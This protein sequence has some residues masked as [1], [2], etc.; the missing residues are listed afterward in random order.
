MKKL[1]FKKFEI[2]IIKNHF[3]RGN[4]LNKQIIIF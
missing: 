4:W 2:K 1:L 3:Y